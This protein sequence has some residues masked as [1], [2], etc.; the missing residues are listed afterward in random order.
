MVGVLRL[1]ATGY[2]LY[3]YCGNRSEY[4]AR[5]GT[6]AAL[7]RRGLLAGDEI[8]PAVRQVLDAA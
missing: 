2:S 6:V 4:G 5:M 7:R 1:A 3:T 8:T